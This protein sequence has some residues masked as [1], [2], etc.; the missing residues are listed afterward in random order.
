MKKLV[1]IF[2]VTM[3]LSFNSSRVG[4]AA[5][6][7]GVYRMLSQSF[8]DGT[9]TQSFPIKQL[10]IF[11]EHYMMYANVNPADS[12]SS[13]GVGS[14]TEGDNM[15]TENI[16]YSASGNS[17]DD[18]SRTFKLAIEKTA[19]GYKQVIRNIGPDEK[20]TL[21]EEYETI[22]NN[23]RSPMDG[24]WKQLKSYNIKGN[25][26]SW[27]NVVQFKTYHAGHFIWGNSFTD[28]S[29]KK[30][31][32]IGF[33]TFKMNSNNKI[34]ETIESSTFSQ[35]NGQTFTVNIEMKGKDW[36]RQNIVDT[37]GTIAVEEYQR[38]KK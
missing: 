10:K 25:D 14:Y 9:E 31:T 33:G 24:V 7:Q 27:N 15:V 28:S 26:T 29:S 32:G 36:F 4:P 30:Y 6:I 35:I 19:K 16:L 34:M 20:F 18:T 23:S 2:S 21:T 12:V 13:F 3:L 5:S 38:F 22:T 8:T 37:D 11:T 1:S 17:S